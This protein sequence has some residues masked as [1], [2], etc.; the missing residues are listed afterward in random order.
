[1]PVA[2]PAYKN[3]T[4][5]GAAS[6]TAGVPGSKTSLPVQFTGAANAVTASGAGLAAIFA[7]AAYAL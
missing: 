3:G 1:M 6:P 2:A 5:A 4:A 7:I